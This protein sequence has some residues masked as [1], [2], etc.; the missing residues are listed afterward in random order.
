MYCD[1]TECANLN[2]CKKHSE[3]KDEY[4]NM[5]EQV[6]FSGALSDYQICKPFLNQVAYGSR[7]TYQPMKKYQGFFTLKS[8]DEQTGN[9]TIFIVHPNQN[10]SVSVSSQHNSKI[11]V[12]YS[13][14]FANFD[15]DT[16]RNCTLS[17]KKNFARS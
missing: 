8:V 12:L 13:E 6:D 7:W 16:F 5:L 4:Y 15:L 3:L 11:T 14:S 17:L 10:V 1:A 2:P 9:V